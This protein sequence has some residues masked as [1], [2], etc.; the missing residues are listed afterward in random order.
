MTDIEQL[1]AEIAELR[2]E[3]ASLREQL[4]PELSPAWTDVWSAIEAN[5]P[6]AKK[7]GG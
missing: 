2:A 6:G 3:L 7:D 5:K 4:F 1:R